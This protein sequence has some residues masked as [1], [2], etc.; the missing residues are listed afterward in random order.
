MKTKQKPPTIDELKLALEDL[1]R[2]RDRAAESQG[3]LDN[4]LAMFKAANA[5]L[6]AA[7]AQQK[8][9]VAELEA[10]VRAAA[11]LYYEA[12]DKST[13]TL[14]PGLSVKEGVDAEITDKNA[15]DAWCREHGLFLTFDEGAFKRFATVEFQAE[16]QLPPGIKVERRAFA[17]IAKEIP[18]QELQLP[19]T[20]ATT[21]AAVYSAGQS[22]LAES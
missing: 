20:V 4:A 9:D 7:A 10:R 6:Y 14:A 8:T 22:G 21:D 18:A 2:A 5:G 11:P 13:K 1:R 12:S 3:Q 16:R 15:A 19:S 17:S